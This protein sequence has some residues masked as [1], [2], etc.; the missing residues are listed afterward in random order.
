MRVLKDYARARGAGKRGGQQIRVTLTGH[1][2]E[3]A[4]DPVAE[5]SALSETL[6]E[7]RRVTLGTHKINVIGRR[8]G[9][10]ARRRA[11]ARES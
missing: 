3:A 10:R 4:A 11:M 9:R 8:S 1:G 5:I 6:H 2:P 7:R